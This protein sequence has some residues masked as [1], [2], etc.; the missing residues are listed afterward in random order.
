MRFRDTSRRRGHRISRGNGR[1]K[2]LEGLTRQISRIESAS[3][4]VH[5]ALTPVIRAEQPE[6]SKAEKTLSA[7]TSLT[8]Y[9]SPLSDSLNNMSL[10][11]SDVSINMPVLLLKLILIE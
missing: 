6:E 10:R 4:S 8:A 5:T 9:A 3:E 2:D 11:V 1:Q 7:P